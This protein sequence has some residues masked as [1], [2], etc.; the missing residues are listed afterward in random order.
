[1]GNPN[2][3]IPR[4][5]LS[6]PTPQMNDSPFEFKSLKKSNFLSESSEIHL[7][8]Q[9]V[10][11]VNYVVVEVFLLSQDNCETLG[12]DDF[13]KQV[14]SELPLLYVEAVSLNLLSNDFVAVE[15]EEP[16]I[17]VNPDHTVFHIVLGIDIE[18]DSFHV[19]V[20]TDIVALNGCQG[21]L[22]IRIC[23]FNLDV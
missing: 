18:G 14:A 6:S 2:I 15:K 12:V 13:L 8:S 9:F 4:L 20:Y 22:I 23:E 3:V 7:Q 11:V 5:L 21:D 17:V 16:I 19:Q 1:M 10:Q